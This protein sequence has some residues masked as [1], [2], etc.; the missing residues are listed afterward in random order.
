MKRITLWGCILVALA[1]CEIVGSPLRAQQI[2]ASI[3]GSVADQGGAVI[4]GATVTVTDVERGSVYTA[5]T[6]DGGLFTFARLPIGTYDVKAE[7]SGFRTAIQSHLTL[8]L[9]QTAR[10]DFKMQVGSVNNT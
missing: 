2:T 4:N 8:V 3:A 9:N 6:G 10:V 5:K 1:A 7:A